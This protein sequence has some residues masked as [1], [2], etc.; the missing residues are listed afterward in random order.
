MP[1]ESILLSIGLLLVFAKILGEVTERFGVSSLTGQI[2]AGILLGPVIG[3]VSVG[4]FLDNFITFGIILLLFLAGLEVK[5]EDI[6]NNIYLASALAI[7]AGMLSFILGMLVGLIFFNNYIIG[8]AIGTVLTSTSNGT[9]FAILMKTRHFTTPTGKLII[10]T[11]I[12]DDIL[13]ILALSLFSFLS[14]NLQP[15]IISDVSALFFI[16][17]GLYLVVLTAGE[18]IV[19]HVLNLFSKFH[20]EQILLALPIAVAFF[21]AYATQ[22][23]GLS[24]AAG[25]FLAGMTMANSHFAS[26]VIEPKMKTIGHGLFIPLFYASIGTLLIIKDINVLLVMSIFLAAVLGKFIGASVIAKIAGL[27]FQEIKLIGISLMPRGNENIALAQLVFVLGLISVQVY[28]SVIF[29]MIATVIVTPIAMKL[30]YE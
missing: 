22:N 2:F 25:A 10:A 6:K 28:T 26:S 20:D 24:L 29:A 3:L 15:N 21:L 19:R 27:R 18:K 5:F 8:F 7:G 1:L 11:T 30:F 14:V 4:S 17:I 13:G 9:L 16:A 23:L 12:A